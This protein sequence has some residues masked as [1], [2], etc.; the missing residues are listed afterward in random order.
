[1]PLEQLTRQLLKYPSKP[2]LLYV[3]FVRGV[4]AGN[5][6]CINLESFGQVELAGYYGI[7]SLSLREILCRKENGNWKAV[8]T[9]MMSSDGNHVDGRAH[10]LVT[11]LM[12]RYFESIFKDRIKDFSKGDDEKNKA[13]KFDWIF[14]YDQFRTVGGRLSP[15]Y[16]DL[17]IKTVC[18]G[19]LMVTGIF[20]GPP[21]FN[22]S[23]VML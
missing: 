17:T 3:N 1:M 8:I 2:A 9:R 7:A 10:A 5:I 20:V 19:L 21:D 16:H 12:I 23:F 22:L 14:G 18:E 4:H 13:A 6:S 15:G 11:T